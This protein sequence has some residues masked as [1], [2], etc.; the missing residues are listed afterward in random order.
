MVFE[1]F[2]S[3]GFVY[4]SP[5]NIGLLPSVVYNRLVAMEN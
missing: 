2:I 4:F 1:A 3:I 5:E